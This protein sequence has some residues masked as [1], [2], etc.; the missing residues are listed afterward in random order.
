MPFKRRK[1]FEDGGITK[2]AD[3]NFHS[4]PLCGTKFPNWLT[5]VDTV[6]RSLTSSECIY[7]YKFQC[8]KC[9]GVFEIQANGDYCFANESF[10]SVKLIN[11]GRGSKNTNKI[12]IPIT[13]EEL[14]S[15]TVKTTPSKSILAAF[16]DEQSHPYTKKS[17]AGKVLSLISLIT[18]IVIMAVSLLLLITSLVYYEFG[19][20]AFSFSLYGI[21]PIIIGIIGACK[22]KCEKNIAITGIILGVLAILFGFLALVSFISYIS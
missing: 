17:T 12:G 9:R 20:F 1:E 18:G 14:K 22:S 11:S 16:D 6:K 10:I 4:C 2:Y 13:I 19:T 8:E 15:L 5:D 21:I 7:G 3:Q